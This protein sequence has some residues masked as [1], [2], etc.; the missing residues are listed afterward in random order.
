MPA[1]AKGHRRKSAVCTLPLGLRERCHKK[2][3]LSQG[4]FSMWNCFADCPDAGLG[5]RMVFYPFLFPAGKIMITKADPDFLIK[6]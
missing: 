5:I 1:E 6:I 2:V 4:S 3:R